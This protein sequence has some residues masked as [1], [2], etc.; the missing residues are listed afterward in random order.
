MLFGTDDYQPKKFELEEAILQLKSEYEHR[1]FEL[2]KVS[3][4]YRFQV[5][6]DMSYWVSKLWLEKPKKYT[7]AL[8]ETL[9][10]IAYRQ[11]ITR[12]DIEDIRGVSVSSNIIKSLFEREWI[13]A[14]GH[15]DL[16]GKPTLYA[17]T[18][19]FLDYFNLEKLADLPDLGD[20]KDVHALAPEL[21]FENDVNEKQ[22]S[23]D[24]LDQEENNEN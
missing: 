1:G 21:D 3:S 20:L 10:I 12:G 18:K 14:V 17:T 9:A 8:L 16:P 22:A 23:P 7:R 5:K 13:R 15:R 24:E 19:Q 11:P 4:G 6:K 2:A